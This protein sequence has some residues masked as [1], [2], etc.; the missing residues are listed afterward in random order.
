MSL[1]TQS[2]SKVSRPSDPIEGFKFDFAKATATG[3][4]TQVG[5]KRSY[6]VITGYKSKWIRSAKPAKL[7]K[8]GQMP[9]S[10]FDEQYIY[11]SPLKLAGKLNDVA[12]YLAQL[13]S[14]P[15]F[16]QSVGIDGFPYG[17]PNGIAQWLQDRSYSITFVN[18]PLLGV[19]ETTQG[20]DPNFVGIK[21]QFIDEVVNARNSQQRNK[22]GKKSTLIPL[23]SIIALYNGAPKSSKT[24]KSGKTVATSAKGANTGNREALL[25]KLQKKRL[26]TIN[27]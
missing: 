24:S 11:C 19:G 15:A 4:Y 3:K 21:Q 7:N 2:T 1:A 16:A 20:A 6:V 8:K 26:R 17:N 9:K 14:N 13:S 23:S 22:S 25:T 5:T 12:T 10:K 27:H 18:N